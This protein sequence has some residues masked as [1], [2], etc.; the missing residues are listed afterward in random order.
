[1]LFREEG[2]ELW[3]NFIS[4][5]LIYF[6][7]PIESDFKVG[8]SVSGVNWHTKW[9][10]GNFYLQLKFVFVGQRNTYQNAVLKVYTGGQNNISVQPERNTANG[11]LLM[12][13]DIGKFVQLP[14]GMFL[15]PR[16]VR[17]WLKR[18]DNL[19]CVRRNALDFSGVTL[20]TGQGTFRLDGEAGLSSRFIGSDESQLPCELIQT[21]AESVNEIS[22]QHGN[23]IGSDFLLNPD[24]MQRFLKIVVLPDGI[25][26]I[27]EFSNS[28]L[29]FVEAFVCPS[30]L[31]LCIRKPDSERHETRV[32]EALLDTKA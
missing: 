14:K 1:V 17:V 30:K 13:V 12:L 3:D 27:P 5:E 21:G 22:Q 9:D 23:G 19:E 10:V 26:I 24:V 11:D 25:S 18:F 15:T 31:H 20:V 6:A 32:P 2:F 28:G 29:E 4:N 7:Q 8:H 16:P